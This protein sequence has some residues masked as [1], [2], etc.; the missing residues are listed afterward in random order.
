MVDDESSF[1]GQIKVTHKTQCL[2]SDSLEETS[3]FVLTQFSRVLRGAKNFFLEFL[4]LFKIYS[5][6]PLVFVSFTRGFFSL[7]IGSGFI[8]AMD[9]LLDSIC[10]VRVTTNSSPGYFTAHDCCRVD[11]SG[12]ALTLHPRT[13]TPSRAGT[14]ARTHARNAASGYFSLIKGTVATSS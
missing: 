11:K 3:K 7:E 12:H 9:C 13:Q 1:R 6:V 14:H 5:D 2:A 4:E 10:S 8:M